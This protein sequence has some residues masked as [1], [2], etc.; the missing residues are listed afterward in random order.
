MFSGDIVVDTEGLAVA[1]PVERGEFT[2]I[3]GDTAVEGRDLMEAEGPGMAVGTRRGAAAL[4]VSIAGRRYWWS[5]LHSRGAATAPDLSSS[6]LRL[7]NTT[8]STLWLTHSSSPT[9]SEVETGISP[10]SQWSGSRTIQLADGLYKL[11]PAAFLTATLELEGVAALTNAIITGVDDYTAI[12]TAFEKVMRPRVETCAWISTLSTRVAVR[13]AWWHVLL[14]RGVP[15][16]AYCELAIRSILLD[17]SEFPLRGRFMG[18]RRVGG[19]AGRASDLGLRTKRA[20]R[21]EEV[22]T[23]VRFAV[24]D[25]ERRP[26]ARWGVRL[27][28]AVAAVMLGMRWGKRIDMGWLLG[29]AVAVSV[30]AKRRRY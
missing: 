9:V 16:W 17:R 26:L 14:A 20:L 15:V 10:V 8:L 3:T 4:A 11:A 21:I 27:L 1:F 5:L 2:W 6:R 30:V 22:M 19:V 28:G 29:R 25:I 23:A 12:F 18:A 7:G 13:Q 24:H